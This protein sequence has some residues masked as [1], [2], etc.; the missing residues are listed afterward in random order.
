MNKKK[1][2]GI[3][4]LARLIKYTWHASP[5]TFIL[6]VISSLFMSSLGFFEVITIQ[7]LFDSSVDVVNGAELKNIYK[8]M[9]VL[10]VILALYPFGEWLEYLARG[11]FWRRGSGY[12]KFLQHECVNK[13]KSITF[14]D[15]KNI[16]ELYLRRIFDYTLSKYYFNISSLSSRGV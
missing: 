16:D 1:I 4:V 5:I 11:Y 13:M 2:S 3:K 6:L 15:S 9:L 7:A 14:E 10:L 8:S 12:M